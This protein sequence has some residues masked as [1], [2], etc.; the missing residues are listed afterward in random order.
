MRRSR[1][2]GPQKWRDPLHHLVRVVTGDEARKGMFY[3]ERIG[4]GIGTLTSF[5]PLDWIVQ[6]RI[7]SK[8]GRRMAR[9][10]FI[11]QL[12]SISPLSSIVFFPLFPLHFRFSGYRNE[13]RY[14]LGCAH[15]SV[16]SRT[17]GR[18]PLPLRDGKT[19]KRRGGKTTTDLRRKSIDRS[20]DIAATK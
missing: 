8:G 11:F 6:M 3:N 1:A 4:I 13:A 2:I 5:Q 15:L 20:I 7:I 10:P 19:E 18:S 16:R 12:R 14:L 9:P 17:H